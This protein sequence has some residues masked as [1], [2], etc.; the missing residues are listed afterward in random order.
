M[1]DLWA[2]ALPHYLEAWGVPVRDLYDGWE[3]R[4]RSTGGFDGVWGVG[5]HHTASRASVDN[6]C[7]YM[8]RNAADRPI[9]NV[10]LDR[11]GLVTVGCAGASN[12]Q[13]KGGPVHTARGAIP[14]DSGNRYLFSIEAANDGAGEVW[15]DAQQSTYVA[16]VCAVM[17]WATHET[18]GPPLACGDVLSHYEWACGRQSKVDPAGPS[19]WSKPSGGGEANMWRMD[20]FRGSVFAHANAVVPVP[21]RPPGDD[22]MAQPD[23]VQ[24]NSEWDGLGV[25]SVCIADPYHQTYRHVGDE[26]ELNQLRMSFDRKGW[27]FPEPIPPIPGWWL[28]QY[29]KRLD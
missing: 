24:I 3:T 8:W 29:G 17:D 20:D 12:T 19:Q 23:V 25:G 21:P 28:K 4:S 10:L 1:G 5:V 18:P 7:A 6:D 15:P 26:D 16:L 11:D 13:G 27:V 14:Q 2:R 9:G 22:D